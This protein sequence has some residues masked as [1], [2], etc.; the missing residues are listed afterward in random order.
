MCPSQDVW[1]QS[2]LWEGTLIQHFAEI[3]ANRLTVVLLQ[4][5]P[6]RA[7]QFSHPDIVIELAI[8]A[9]RYE[10]MRFTDFE[11]ALLL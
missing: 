2:L 5:I 10:G 3:K 7:S 11:N 9:C 1:R 8:I 6:S 4:D